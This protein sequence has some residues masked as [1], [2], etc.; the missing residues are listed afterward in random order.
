MAEDFVTRD[1]H[2][3]DLAELRL[4]LANTLANL[5][6]R[7]ELITQDLGSLRREVE[8]MRG[9]LRQE[10]GALRSD[11]RREMDG[12]RQETQGFRQEIQ[13][14][15]QEM[16]EFRQDM[17]RFHTSTTRQM[18]TMISVVLFAVLTGAIKLVFFPDW[19]T[20]PLPHR[21]L[22]GGCRLEAAGE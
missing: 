1:Q 11:T 4:E 15:R 9:D 12:L 2:R 7:T 13:G 3:A 22:S 18:W 10:I 14:L 8:S 21:A 19:S 5:D 20:C 6:K 17:A 16:R